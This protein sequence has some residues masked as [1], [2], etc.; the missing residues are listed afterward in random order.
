MNQRQGWGLPSEMNFKI[1]AQRNQPNQWPPP[2]E[3]HGV[4]C[5][6]ESD[7]LCVTQAKKSTSHKFE[8]LSELFYHPPVVSTYVEPNRITKL[9]WVQTKELLVCKSHR[10]KV[11]VDIHQSYGP[12]SIRCCEIFCLYFTCLFLGGL[13]PRCQW[14]REEYTIHPCIVVSTLKNLKFWALP[15]PRYG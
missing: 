8:K 6:R 11:L 15:S 3:R 9:T 5:M 1:L 4:M 10:C 12:L 7:W 14:Y 13:L 2:L